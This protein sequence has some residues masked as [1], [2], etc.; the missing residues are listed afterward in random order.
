MIRKRVSLA[1]TYLPFG[2]YFISKKIL[3]NYFL[4]FFFKIKI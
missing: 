2:M 3:V 4:V 1:I